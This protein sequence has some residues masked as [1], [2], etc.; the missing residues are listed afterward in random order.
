MIALEQPQ[1]VP[2][3]ILKEPRRLALLHMHPT[4]S[5]HSLTAALAKILEAKKRQTIE[6]IQN[7]SINPSS[8][9]EALRIEGVRL[10]ELNN[11]LKLIYD[12]KQ[13]P[14]QYPLCD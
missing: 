13:I 8:N 3:E 6:H 1:Q 11:T 7:L 10:F 12:T 2:P 5:Q 9:L 14:Q 4:W